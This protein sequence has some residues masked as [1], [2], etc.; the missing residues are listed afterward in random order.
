M[1]AFDRAWNLIKMGMDLSSDKGEYFRWNIWG[2]QDILT[3]MQSKK[4]QFD[5][6]IY[7]TTKDR[8]YNENRQNNQ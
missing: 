5:A 6:N 8:N 2:W 4:I 1:T 7:A 3:L